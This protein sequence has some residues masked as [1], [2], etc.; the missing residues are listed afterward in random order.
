MTQPK[1]SIV[2]I[3]YNQCAFLERA[4]QSVLAQ[5]YPEVEYIVVDP[6]S[7]DGSRDIIERYRSRISKLILEPDKGPVDGLNKG[8]S[9]ATGE[10]YGYLNAD[11]EFLPGAIDKAMRAFASHRK[12]KSFMDTAT[13]W[14]ATVLSFVEYVLPHSACGD[15]C[16]AQVSSCSLPHFLEVVRSST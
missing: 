11:D 8:F 16:T 15:M 1:V 5:N 9:V 13:R 3:S 7:T 12:L 6:G 4:I 2:T 10:I 14:M